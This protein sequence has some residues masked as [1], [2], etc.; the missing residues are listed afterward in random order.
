M[1]DRFKSCHLD[2]L[3]PVGEI[4]TIFEKFICTQLNKTANTKVYSDNCLSEEAAKAT[5]GT[6]NAQKPFRCSSHLKGS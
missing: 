3:Y 6:V 2:Q 1:S 4:V 5:A